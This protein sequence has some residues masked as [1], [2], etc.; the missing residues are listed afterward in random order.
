MDQ[1]FA[2]KLCDFGWICSALE[3]EFDYV[4][5]TFEYLSPEVIWNNL[6]TKKLDVWCL[7]VLF[8]E[9]LHGK[10]PFQA[11]SLNEIKEKLKKSQIFINKNLSEDS[12]NLLKELLKRNHLNRISVSDLLK[13]K[14][15]SN[16]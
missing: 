15:F 11:E 4:C 9:M 14:A 2:I 16:L 3:K 7:G 8:Y 5:G 13:H 12:K 10:P 6:H 1:N